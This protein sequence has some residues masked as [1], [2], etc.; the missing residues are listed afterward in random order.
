[1]W[2]GETHFPDFT[3]EDV[4]RLW[5]EYQEKT[6]LDPGVAGIW[7]DMNEPHT[8]DEKEF[9]GRVIQHDFGRNRT[10]ERV[11]QVYGH[12]MA[13]ASRDGFRRAR[14]RQRPFVIT[15]SGWAGVQRH[16]LVWT[17]DNQS[18][19][20]SM[21]LDLQL[22]LSMG[23]SAVSFV[24]C[25]IG[26][27]G[28]DGCS[29]LY[30]RWIEWGVFQPFCRTHTS[31]RTIDQEPWSFGPQVEA[32]ARKMIE[33]RMRLLPYMYSA[34]VEASETGAPVNRPL[35]YQYPAD[36]QAQRIADQFLLGRDLLVAPVLQPAADRRMVYFPEGEWVDWWTGNRHS[37]M[38]W[39]IVDAPLGQP[40]VFAR[41]GAVI[42][43]QE[44]L[45][46][47][48]AKRLPETTLEVFVA[49][50]IDGDLVEDDGNT[51]KWEEG[52]ELRTRFS[53]NCTGKRIEFVIHEP[54][55]KYTGPRKHWRIRLHSVP[56]IPVGVTCNGRKAG[57]VHRDGAW[58]FF[59]QDR[60]R[61]TRFA[62][63]LK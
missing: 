43:T 28:L 54:T 2:P 13:Q 5:G 59:A 10:H 33:T 60:R 56:G 57:F 12:C 61:E 39:R 35:V 20:A 29:E 55:G 17:G 53:G 38:T 50:K 37:G 21:A 49:G 52:F 30:A 16:A 62:V 27:F 32:V 26:G 31:I 42:P 8:F 22:N 46:H 48:G 40:P 45:Q 24:G 18:T 15:R 25:D 36:R 6:L 44:A 4:R 19:W 63:V 34:F 23:L 7:N 58:E 3:R 9:P 51:R 11:H 47:T 14:P 1:V 41:A